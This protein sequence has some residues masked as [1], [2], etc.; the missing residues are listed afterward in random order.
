MER[1]SQDD[2][3]HAECQ[4]SLHGWADVAHRASIAPEPAIREAADREKPMASVSRVVAPVAANGRP[5]WPAPLQ[6]ND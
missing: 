5:G 3:C 6:T 4:D 1:D 2:G